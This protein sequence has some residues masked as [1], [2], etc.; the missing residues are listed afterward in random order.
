MELPTA[1]HKSVVIFIAVVWLL[2]G[3]YF[4]F[5]SEHMER[6]STCAFISRA[7]QIWITPF[8]D[9]GSCVC[10]SRCVCV[11]VFVCLSHEP[12]RATDLRAGRLHLLHHDSIWLLCV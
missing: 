4:H 2:F 1:T 9:T 3:I 10:K 8:P 12:R 11:G 6:Y 5:S 7:S